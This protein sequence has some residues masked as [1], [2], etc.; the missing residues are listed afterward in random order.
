MIELLIFLAEVVFI[1]SLVKLLLCKRI[2]PLIRFHNKIKYEIISAIV[3]IGLTVL[4]AYFIEGS[5]IY[6]VGAMLGIIQ[7]IG[8]VVMVS[9]SVQDE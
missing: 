8:S 3:I 9:E 7:G 1:M 4:F 2:S 5:S 6:L